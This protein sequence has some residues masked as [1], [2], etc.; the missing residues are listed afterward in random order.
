MPRSGNQVGGCK[1]AEWWAN[2]GHEKAVTA[3]RLADDS[4]ETL[5]THDVPAEVLASVWPPRHQTST[6]FGEA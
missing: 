1:G 4:P 5:F 6:L 3:Q 2:T